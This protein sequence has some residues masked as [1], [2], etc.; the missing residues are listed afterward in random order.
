[1]IIGSVD[2]TAETQEFSYCDSPLKMV[3]YKVVQKMNG[4]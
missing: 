2:K 4:D 1:M 3:K